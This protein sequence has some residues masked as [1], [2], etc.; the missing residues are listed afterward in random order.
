MKR[1]VQ[2]TLISAAFFGIYRLEAHQAPIEP[3]PV[4]PVVLGESTTS[5]LD[6]TTTVL[7][8][9]SNAMRKVPLKESLILDEAAQNRAYFFCE[10]EFGHYTGGVTPY[11]FL[12]AVGY[13]YEY[14]GENLAR[15][16][17]NPEKMFDAFMNSPKHRDNILDTDYT[18]TGMAEA[19]GIVVVYFGSK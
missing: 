11:I 8:K 19:C 9:L 7:F 12:H 15:G 18:E 4:V 16:Y 17:A 13:E 5:H 14:A 2:I 3:A 10:N 1:I 6:A